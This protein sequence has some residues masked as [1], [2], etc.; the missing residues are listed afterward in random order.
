LLALLGDS[1]TRSYNLSDYI[2]TRIFL[3][4]GQKNNF[5]NLLNFAFTTVRYLSAAKRLKRGGLELGFVIGEPDVR[6]ITYGR[7]DV[8][9]SEN[10]L[11][12]NQKLDFDPQAVNK[13]VTRIR[14]FL[15]VTRVFRRDPLV[16]IGC[17]TPNPKMLPAGSYFNEQLNQVCQ[18]AG[19]L[20]FDPQKYTYS[21]DGGIDKKFIGFSV[22]D[23]EKTDHTHLSVEISE[24]FDQ[25]LCDQMKDVSACR[26]D[27]K[28]RSKFSRYFVKVRD[29]DTYRPVESWFA[30]LIKLIRRLFIAL[31]K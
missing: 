27:W 31:S 24:Y 23:P 29:F 2:S 16:I 14:Y 21:D 26:L 12:S 28:E 11:E 1:H 6:W 30:K 13:V 22:F 7:W 8:G 19:C 5:K 20:F 17:G 4:Q 10:I 18:D 25:F 3:S 15:A 9:A